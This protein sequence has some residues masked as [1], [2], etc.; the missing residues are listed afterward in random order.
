M[1]QIVCSRRVMLCGPSSSSR[2]MSA[3]VKLSSD[4]DPPAKHIDVNSELFQATSLKCESFEDRTEGRHSHY[5]QRATTLRLGDWQ[6]RAS[7][8]S[9]GKLAKGSLGRCEFLLGQLAASSSPLVYVQWIVL[10]SCNLDEFCVAT[11]PFPSLFVFLSM[12]CVNSICIM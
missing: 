6:K 7:V 12:D 2:P 8:L 3:V 9:V 1:A 11:V 5:L 10:S 4:V